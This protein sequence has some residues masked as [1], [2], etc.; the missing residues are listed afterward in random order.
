M[1]FCIVILA[2][3]FWIMVFEYVF[4]V[5]FCITYAEG[6]ALEGSETGRSC[7]ITCKNLFS[8]ITNLVAT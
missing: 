8:I 2:C 7:S 6:R 4:S 1:I 5:H 3:V